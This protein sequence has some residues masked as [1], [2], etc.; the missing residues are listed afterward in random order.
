MAQAFCDGWGMVPL[1]AVPASE[2]EV[3]PGPFS[4]SNRDR[5]WVLSDSAGP[6]AARFVIGKCVNCGAA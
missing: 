4:R 6:I 2:C 1:L 3:L 5:G